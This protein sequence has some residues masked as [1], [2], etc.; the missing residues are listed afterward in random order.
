[1]KLDKLDIKTTEVLDWNGVNLF[2]FQAIQLYQ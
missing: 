2:H 1:M